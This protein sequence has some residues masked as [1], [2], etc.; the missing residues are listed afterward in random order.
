MTAQ[1]ALDVPDK[2][3][4]PAGFFKWIAS[5]AGQVVWREF[6]KRALQ[7]AKKRKRYSAR[8]IMEVVRWNTTIKDGTTEFKISNNWIPGLARLWMQRHGETYPD[9][10]LLHD[11][12]GRKDHV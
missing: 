4:Y 7:M 11:T 2:A 8:T 3:G 1:L 5:D 10:F 6:N 9:F 12:L